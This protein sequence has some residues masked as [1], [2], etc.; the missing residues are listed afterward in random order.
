MQLY[1]SLGTWLD[2]QNGEG[3]NNRPLIVT[4]WNS[5]KLTK[6]GSVCFT[7]DCHTGAD[8][9]PSIYCKTRSEELGRGKY[10]ITQSIKFRLSETF[11]LLRSK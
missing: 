7:C 11:I 3:F 1:N 8:G 5:F 9:S 10:S 2:T 6:G 4:I